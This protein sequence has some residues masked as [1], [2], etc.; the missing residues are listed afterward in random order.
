MKVYSEMIK[1]FVSGFSKSKHEHLI[2]T[3]CLKTSYNKS[4]ILNVV[5]EEF[6]DNYESGNKISLFTYNLF[7]WNL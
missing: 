7:D 5:L 3:N 1:S 2:V 4:D 6:F